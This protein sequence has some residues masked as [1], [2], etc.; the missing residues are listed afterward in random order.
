[1]PRLTSLPRGLPGILLLSLLWTSSAVAQLDF[2]GL[3]LG[4][5]PEAPSEEA[6]MGVESSEGTGAIGA[7]GFE[8]GD[9]L[10]TLDDRHALPDTRLTVG[11]S[12]GV[13]SYR[14]EA[15]EAAAPA[16]PAGVMR[17]EDGAWEVVT[18]AG[19][20]DEWVDRPLVF[21]FSRL[22]RPHAVYDP[23]PRL[24]EV[25]IAGQVAPAPEGR[26]FHQRTLQPVSREDGHLSRQIQALAWED[27]SQAAPLLRDLGQ[28]ERLEAAMAVVVEAL[29]SRG[30]PDA[31]M[32]L[33]AEAPA[34]VRAEGARGLL[35]GVASLGEAEA[36]LADLT[37]PEG[38][39]LL[40]EARD[41]RIWMAD[42]YLRRGQVEEADAHAQAGLPSNPAMLPVG[43]VCEALVRYHLGRDDWD[44][45]RGRVAD[46]TSAEAFVL[47][48][49]RRRG[50]AAAVG[51]L[52]ALRR[53]A[54][55]RYPIDYHALEELE[56]KLGW[57]GSGA[58]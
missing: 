13:F 43:R 16:S 17:R 26:R 51:E 23:H 5:G 9:E 7:R 15:R 52:E 2:S 44:A 40:D 1:M 24:T 32:T 50:H 53:P 57:A 19:E 21:V 48:T 54:D 4:Q 47:E 12:V 30:D 55:H 36:R 6:A 27:P 11:D 33:L 20:P 37:G 14:F 34:A 28:E 8:P 38:G 58:D 3:A 25:F 45:A 10:V 41:L 39:A 22:G 29:A 31:A 18:L 46:A 35:A 56:A 49:L 42:A